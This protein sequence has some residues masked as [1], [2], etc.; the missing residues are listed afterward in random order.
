MTAKRE[1]AVRGSRVRSCLGVVAVVLVAAS[2]FAGEKDQLVAKRAKGRDR[3]L[4]HHALYA[5]DGRL[6][7]LHD[8]NGVGHEDFVYLAQHHGNDLAF[9]VMTFADSESR[10]RVELGEGYPA[11]LGMVKLDADEAPEFVAAF[12]SRRDRLTKKALTMTGTVIASALFSFYTAPQTGYITTFTYVGAPSGLDLQDL[13]AIDDDGSIV[14]R[15]ELREKDSGG[16]LDEV[17]FPMLVPMDGAK[18]VMIVPTNIV[19]GISG[20]D[21]TT[22]WAVPLP[23]DAPAATWFNAGPFVEGTVHPALFFG[24]RLVVLDPRGGA[25]KLSEPFEMSIAQLPAWTVFG[26]GEGAGILVFSEEGSRLEMVSIATRKPIWRRDVEGVRPVLPLGTD[27]FAVV[28]K[29]GLQILKRHGRARLHDARQGQDQVRSRG[30]GQRRRRFA[31]VR[32]RVGHEGRVL[33]PAVHRGPVGRIARELRRRRQPGRAV[34]HVLRPRRL[35][36]PPGR[37]RRRQGAVAVGQDRRGH[38]EGR[39]GV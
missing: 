11:G 29:H 21:G 38:P 39:C 36:R 1:V 2:V 25:V 6:G 28:W 5:K 12:G 22:V 17:R 13:V 14:W 10:I 31:R 33:E 19:L 3:E 32:V 7:F 15:R 27:S 30:P 35:S 8:V 34:R 24:N 9:H 18:A 26:S 37:D 16:Q 20:T 23:G 4:L